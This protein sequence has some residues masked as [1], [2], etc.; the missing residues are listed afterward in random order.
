MSQNKLRKKK[1]GMR[2]T[3]NKQINY[4]FRVYESAQRYMMMLM[5]TGLIY[6]N[7]KVFKKRHYFLKKVINEELNEGEAKFYII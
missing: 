6:L 2:L 7:L 3:L 4:G 5:K 1:T